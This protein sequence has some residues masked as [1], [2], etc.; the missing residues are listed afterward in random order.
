M[1]NGIAIDFY[2][3]ELTDSLQQ[4]QRNSAESRADFHQSFT[5]LRCNSIENAP[6]D[7]CIVQKVLTETFARLMTGHLFV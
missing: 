3:I 6:D 7:C 2:C 5:G 1:A 4:R